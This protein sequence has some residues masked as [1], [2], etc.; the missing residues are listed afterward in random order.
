[1]I[2]LARNYAQTDVMLVGLVIYAVLGLASDAVVRLIQS[3]ALVWRRTL[4]A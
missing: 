2:T 1:M 4:A 3:R